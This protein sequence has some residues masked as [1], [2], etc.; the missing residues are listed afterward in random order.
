M[1]NSNRLCKSKRRKRGIEPFYS[2]LEGGKGVRCR[3]NKRVEK[4]D[5]V[6]PKD[7]VNKWR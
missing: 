4:Y 1:S 2:V 6:S 7:G 3:K 5:W